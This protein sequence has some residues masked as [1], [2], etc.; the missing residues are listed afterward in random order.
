MN[1]QTV[2]I[3][4]DNEGVRNSIRE[5]VESVGLEAKTYASALTYL[6]DYDP[7]RAGCLVLDI[8]MANMSGL[9]LQKKLNEFKQAPPIIFITGHGE[10]PLAVEAVKAGAVDFIQKPY[11]EQSLLNSINKALQLDKELRQADAEQ[12][13]LE[14]IM[15]KLTKRELEVVKLLAEGH[16][17]KE[18]ALIL[19]ISTRTAEV[20]RK[21]IMQKLELNSASDLLKL[22]R[23]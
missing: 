22:M 16:S 1:E 15:E 23:K 4:D 8:R 20:H 5:L 18:V 9:E 17:N 12:N 7:E 21:N 19:D 11:H 3:V 13:D 2:F 6:D 14:T 10:V